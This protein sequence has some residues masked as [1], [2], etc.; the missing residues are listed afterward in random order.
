MSTVQW[1]SNRV[2]KACSARG[3][4]AMGEEFCVEKMG[5]LLESLHTGPLQP[6]YATAMVRGRSL[7]SSIRDENVSQSEMMTE[8]YSSQS[9]C[10]IVMKRR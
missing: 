6:C 3:P 1:R 4:I 8:R 5:T 10:K 7:L 2:C 9:A